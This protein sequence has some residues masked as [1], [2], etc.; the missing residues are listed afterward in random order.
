V[1]VL[2]QGPLSREQIMKKMAT[3]L[4]ARMVQVEL[5]KL[6]KMV[7]LQHR[8]LKEDDLFSGFWRIKFS[9]RISH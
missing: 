4:T 9:M 7:Q 6:K 2:K 3:P 8:V 1:E 5:S